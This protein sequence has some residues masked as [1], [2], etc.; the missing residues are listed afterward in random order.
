MIPGSECIRPFISSRALTRQKRN[1][2]KRRVKK[3]DGRMRGKKERST[4]ISDNQTA[5]EGSHGVIGDI[6]LDLYPGNIK[7]RDK[8]ILGVWPCI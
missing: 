4:G 6:D 8:S 7:Y 5:S 2:E 1:K 3:N